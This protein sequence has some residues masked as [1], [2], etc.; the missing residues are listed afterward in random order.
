MIAPTLN[1]I[2]LT[3]RV[4]LT[5]V[6]EYRWLP[7]L[8]A[9]GCLIGSLCGC[10]TD[11][12]PVSQ[13]SPGSIPTSAVTIRQTDAEGRRL[14]FVTEFPDRWNTGNDGTDYEPC[15]AVTLPVLVAAGLNPATTKD[16][17]LAN[18]QTLRGCRWNYANS[19]LKTLSQIVANS[20]PLDEYK[21]RQSIIFRWF[22]DTSINGRRVAVGAFQEPNRCMAIVDTGRSHVSTMVSISI[23]PPPVADICAKA[24]D[25][26]RATI[27][28]IPE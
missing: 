5:F 27:D 8:I 22:S 7:W 18:Y 23:D 28:Q 20:E 13:S 26:T 15:T 14:P 9:T 17:A 1:Y 10:S 12:S 19:S 4:R 3:R 11:G 6:P 2:A 25:F 21:E 24:V 16:A